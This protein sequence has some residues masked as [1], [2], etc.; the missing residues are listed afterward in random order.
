MMK[1][2]LLDRPRERFSSVGAD[3]LSN[4][5]LLAII[6]GSGTRGQ[7]VVELSH[8]LLLRFGSLSKL[9]DAT[10]EE[11]MEVKGIGKAKAI[12]L[13]A[14]FTIAKRLLRD[15]KNSLRK[16]RNSEDGYAALVD[17]FEGE[18][19]EM[20]AVLLLDAKSS[21]FHREI[22]GRGTLTQVLVHPREIFKPAVRHLAHS[23]I[24]AHNHPSGDPKPSKEDIRLTKH[25]I[26]CSQIMQIPLADHIIIGKNCYTSLKDLNL[27]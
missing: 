12:Q 6:L 9:I 22:I 11:L 4:A 26:E 14:L 13:R 1:V 17:L 8:E 5:E 16:I 24:I 10:T 27:L 25:L 2:P 20:I 7:S 18:K 23:M 15:E 21:L 19:Q 3:S